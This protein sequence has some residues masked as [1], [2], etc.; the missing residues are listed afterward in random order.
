MSRQEGFLFSMKCPEPIWS[1]CI[2]LFFP[3]GLSDRDMQRR[4]FANNMDIKRKV[5]PRIGH[6]H[7]Q[8]E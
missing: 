6:D 2:L 5:Y 3:R 8:K 4:N 1:S 7:P